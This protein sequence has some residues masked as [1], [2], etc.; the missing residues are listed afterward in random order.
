[1][2]NKSVILM[3]MLCTSTSSFAQLSIEDCYAKAKAN[4][5]LIKQYDLIEQTR[6]YNLSNITRVWLPQVQLSA[7]VTY[8]SEVT[9]I[10]IDFSKLKPLLGDNLPL[11]PK[12]SKDQ[13]GGNH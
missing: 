1:M 5:P 12:L 9:Q 13:S 8:Q 2:K 6:D 11:I 3:L 4:Y 10:P 7:K